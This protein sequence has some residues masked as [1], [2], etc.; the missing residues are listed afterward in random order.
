MGIASPLSESYTETEFRVC[1][2]TMSGFSH[3]QDPSHIVL[4]DIY[5]DDYKKQANL[6]VTFVTTDGSLKAHSKL[7]LLLS[8]FFQ[9]KIEGSKRFGSSLEFDYKSYDPEA[10]KWFLDYC[11][12][13]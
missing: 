12:C 8:S 7:L 1:K 13:A 6:D 3:C 11:Y 9:N 4:R 2:F 10:V 5:Y